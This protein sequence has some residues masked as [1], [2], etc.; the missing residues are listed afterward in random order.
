M[1]HVCKE[2]I[3]SKIETTMKLVFA[4]VAECPVTYNEKRKPAEFDTQRNY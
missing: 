4:I 2:E 3:L 1:E